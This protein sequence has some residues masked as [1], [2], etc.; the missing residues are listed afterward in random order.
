STSASR[1]PT[2]RLNNVDLPTLG[3]PTM[4]RLSVMAGLPVRERWAPLPERQ[5]HQTGTGMGALRLKARLG[6]RAL[7][8]IAVSRPPSSRTKSVAF[9]TTGEIITPRL[10][11]SQPS[12]LPVYG[13]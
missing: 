8:R 12:T 4:A 11:L 6:A 13:E 3:R 9:A 10:S 2:R 1:R 7:Q 5:K